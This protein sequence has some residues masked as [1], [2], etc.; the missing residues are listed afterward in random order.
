MSTEFAPN[1]S[2]ETQFVLPIDPPFIWP[3]P[4]WHE[5]QMDY[6][7]HHPFEPLV[8]HADL[9]SGALVG[10]AGRTVEWIDTMMR[11]E[12]ARRIVLVLVIYPAGPTEFDDNYSL[13]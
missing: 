2:P 4:R 10:A 1:P 13:Y 12:G 8:A 3:E 5:G 6:E 7:H 9:I 11:K